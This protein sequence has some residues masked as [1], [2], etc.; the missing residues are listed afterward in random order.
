MG[1][2]QKHLLAAMLIMVFTALGLA[3]AQAD[4]NSSRPT[5]Y[6]ER[7]NNAQFVT[8]WNT[9]MENAEMNLEWCSISSKPRLVIFY[10]G[11]GF[12]LF[13]LARMARENS[14]R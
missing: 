8:G 9:T 6:T 12:S 1:A 4:M 2:A 13:L 5:N 3:T 14:S 10:L 11:I 7:T